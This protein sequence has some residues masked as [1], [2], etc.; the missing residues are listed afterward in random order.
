MDQ[1]LRLWYK[2]PATCHEETLP[3][4]NGR[5]G[6]MIFGGVENEVLALNEDSLWSG[7]RREK[8]RPEAREYLPLAR[9]LIQEGKL[10]EAEKM[11]QNHMLGEYTESYLPLGQLT[12][13]YTYKGAGS[14][15]EYKRELLLDDATSS[16]SYRVDGTLYQREFFASYPHQAIF[17]RL[18][19]EK[20]EMTVSVRF[21]SQLSHTAEA[22]VSQG[23]FG[24]R[25]AGQCPEHV[26]PPYTHNTTKIIQGTKGQFFKAGCELL[27]TDGT[28]QI[29]GEEICIANASNIVLAL[30]AVKEATYSKAEDFDSLKK[31][32]IE[33]YQRIFKTVELYLGEQKEEPTDERLERMKV[34]DNDPA[35]YALYF[36]YGR[37]LLIS[38][39][40]KGGQPANLQGIWSW[41]MQAP[42]CSNWTTNINLQMNYWH[43]CSCNLL[44]C[45]EPYFELLK[46]VCENGKKTAKVHYGC[47]GSVLHHNTDYWASTNPTGIFYGR[48]KGY[49]GCVTW[50][51][52]V[53]GGAWLCR[54]LYQYYEYTND[55][56]FLKNTA[57]PILRENVLFLNDWLTEKEGVY[58]VLPSTSPE[59]RFLLQDGATCCVS[60]NCAMDLELV[61]EVFT[62]YQKV[63]GIMG[64]EE[65]L[66]SEIGGKLEHLAPLKVGS[67][68]Q[69]LE[70]AEEYAEAEPGHR[71]MS[72]VYGMYPSELFANDQTMLDACKRTLELRIEN[73]GG[74][75]GWSCAWLINLFSVLEDNENAY[76]YLYTLLTKSTYNNLWD[77]HPPFQIDGNFGGTAGI[78]NMLVQDRG[79]KVKIL[80]ALPAKWQNGYVK[81]LRIK[82]NQTIDIEWRNGKAVNVKVEDIGRR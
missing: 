72:Q 66:L 38:S 70:W 46:R 79:G 37:Y 39:S 51:F 81:G 62:N 27:C 22:G 80:P 20:S 29:T 21:D 12:F 15:T 24:I 7:Y 82:G 45:L 10:A 5:L 65:K 49:D 47:R 1:K 54:E 50:S 71:H 36:Q 69:L 9:K 35:L 18:T 60:K 23:S 19:C 56:E 26:E 61:R 76:K 73:G 53:L 40:R 32:H 11:I 64:M 44:E 8:N 43:A 14:I 6:A 4:G 57:Y 58:E 34:E 17:A 75:T 2:K 33:D 78:A 16:V 41:R 13:A 59:N 31:K 28:V 67:K 55:V 63:C 48:D 3:I 74:Y 30:N 25:I 68:G 42:W 52:W 77:A